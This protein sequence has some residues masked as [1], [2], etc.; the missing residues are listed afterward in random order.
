MLIKYFIFFILL[1]CAIHILLIFGISL[2]WVILGI[3]SILKSFGF[4][5]DSE[6][7]YYKEMMEKA[8]KIYEQ[9]NASKQTKIEPEE[10]TPLNLNVK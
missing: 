5:E 1:F 6:K 3:F 7:K 9:M 8:N 2:T 10:N 4:I